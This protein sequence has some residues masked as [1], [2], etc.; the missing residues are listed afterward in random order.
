MTIRIKLLQ[1][2]RLFWIN[3]KLRKKTLMIAHL[4]K[5]KNPIP[6]KLKTPLQ[7]ANLN[8]KKSHP[9]KL[10]PNPLPLTTKASAKF[11]NTC[12]NSTRNVKNLNCNASKR[13]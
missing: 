13:P 3:I 2:L 12:K 4:Q 1:S 5:L 8:T 7:N 11:P 6:K 10:S 9:L